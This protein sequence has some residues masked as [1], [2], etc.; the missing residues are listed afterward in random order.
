MK[1]R[2]IACESIDELLPVI[3]RTLC[4]QNRS[5]V[6]IKGEFHVEIHVGDYIYRIINFEIL[7]ELNMIA[8]L[9][10]MYDIIH[11]DLF[12]TN[13]MHINI[14]YKEKEQSGYKKYTKKDI[15]KGNM[16]LPKLY[17]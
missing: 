15:K 7:K 8:D 10:K 17:R 16:K 14:N 5:Y 12:I 9:F 3:E 1:V 2:K 11:Q 13:D 4:K 6:V